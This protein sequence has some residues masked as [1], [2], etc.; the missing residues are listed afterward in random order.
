VGASAIGRA[1]LTV[2][3]GGRHAQESMVTD[4]ERQERLFAAINALER[5]REVSD[6]VA[7]AEILDR[8]TAYLRARLRRGL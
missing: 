1:G 5:L 8:W 2:V 4:G 3:A 7:F 6:D